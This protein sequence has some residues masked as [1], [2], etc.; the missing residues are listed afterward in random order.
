MGIPKK[1]AYDFLLE[2][3]NKKRDTIQKQLDEVTP[4]RQI[5]CH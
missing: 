3:L 4:D 1:E 5:N 2:G